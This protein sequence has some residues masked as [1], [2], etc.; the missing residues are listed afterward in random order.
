LKVNFNLLFRQLNITNHDE[1]ALLAA[2][3][4]GGASAA[5]TID[6]LDCRRNKLR[7]GGSKHCKRKFV[8]RDFN[9]GILQLSRYSAWLGTHLTNLTFQVAFVG[10]E[11]ILWKEEH[12]EDLDGNSHH[13]GSFV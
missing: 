13:V 5:P 7:L 3:R 8:A 11:S 12:H 1:G 4:L 6:M 10:N 9:P 2:P